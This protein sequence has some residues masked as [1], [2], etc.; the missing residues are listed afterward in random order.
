[1]KKLLLSLIML[2]F[3]CFTMQAQPV[4]HLDRTYGGPLNDGGS[5]VRQTPD[6]GYIMVGLTESYGAGGTDI[7]LI[8]ADKYG[9]ILWTK[10]YGGTG[11][12]RIMSAMNN[13]LQITADGGY[14][15]IGATTSFGAG[16]W[17]AW[18][19]KTDAY[20]DTLWTKTFG[21][22]SLDLGYVVYQTN[23]GGYIFTGQ[24]WGFGSYYNNVWLVKTDADGNLEWQK[25]YP[26]Y[27]YEAGQSLQQTADGGYLVTGLTY[28]APYAFLL[29]TDAD[30][31]FEWENNI[32]YGCGYSIEKT[33]D[34]GFIICGTTGGD[35]F[36]TKT[37]ATG[38]IL[39]TKVITGPGANF[40]YAIQQLDD[41]GYIVAGETNGFGGGWDYYVFRTDASGDTLWTQVYGGPGNEWAKSIQI[42][43]DGGYVM[44]GY[45]TSFGAGEGDFW[46]LKIKEIEYPGY[47]T[48]RVYKD[49]DDNCIYNETIDGLL[50]GNMLKAEPGPYY[51]FTD[52]QG[53]YKFEVEP[54][55]YT[56]S[57]AT[58]P[59]ELFGFQDCQLDT[60]YT[61]TVASGSVVT[62]NDFALGT[63]DPP[64]CEG[65]VSI[66][67]APFEQGDCLP[68]YTLSSPC[69]GFLHR[70]CFTITNT[71]T[72]VIG[73]G[74]NVQVALDPNMT[75]SSEVSNTCGTA[76]V[77]DFSDISNPVW[78]VTNASVLNN[79][80]KF[81]T[82]CF[83]VNVLG[84]PFPF[85]SPYSTTATFNACGEIYTDTELDYDVCSC[86]PNDKLV[87]PKGC[88]PYG[89][90]GRDEN[91]TYNI[92]FQNIGTGPAHNVVIRDT[93]D[94]DFDIFTLN[95]LNTSHTITGLQIN[96]GNEIVFSFEGIELP[97]SLS[98]PQGSKGFIVMELMPL[99]NL[100]NGTELTNRAA[101]YFDNNPPV[102][103]NTT[104]NTIR[105]Y[106]Y[107]IADFTA[108][109][110][111]ES[112]TDSYDFFYTGNTADNAT[113]YWDFG[114]DATPQF[115]TE[116]DPL[117]II[118][119]STGLKDVS[120]TLTR[121][122]CTSSVIQTIDVI[123]VWCG[124]NNNKILV[125]HIPPGNPENPQTICISLNALP[126]HLAHG[127]C[128]GPCF[129]SV[130]KK[131][132][133]ENNNESIVD[134]AIEESFIAYPNPFSDNTILSFTAS[135]ENNVLL[136]VYN[137]TGQKVATLFD[138][139][140][141]AGKQYKVE[142]N[143]DDLPQ[144]VYIGVL[145]DN[146][147][148]K[149]IRL[150]LIK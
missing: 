109:R 96:P 149:V 112:I 72:Q 19:I 14:I 36:L 116:K 20:G 24:T 41:G 122:G 129:N 18:L 53:N 12:D 79:N 45:T 2:A 148:T 136:Q 93:I 23:D 130:I 50:V 62:D 65:S 89:N 59:N 105:D 118:F 28:G 17:D 5:T 52:K 80:G 87:S 44:L 97:D 121:Y 127:D 144:G 92:R 6:G 103:T 123:N 137:Y 98:D 145:Q 71:G 91:I 40:A 57:P 10:T 76:L 77:G 101:I 21:S 139:T 15:I 48:G 60:S 85:G 31:N 9:D 95:I 32:I 38:N 63:K 94:F 78:N 64:V 126:A 108:N 119:S 49:D 81:C 117:G 114:A 142:F 61:V 83:N 35:S 133:A 111:C 143:T 104:L 124:N 90:T 125:C 22:P 68:P 56:V 141:V 39:W 11:T 27:N 42:T 107:P 25:N 46:L 140:V 43:D 1:M 113:F 82:V 70:Y 134:I 131:A 67:S 120:L 128:V 147:E 150:S 74:S 100:P 51:V 8:K 13:N 69:P 29:K 58:I 102:I 3:F 86:D 88:G 106:P 54:D 99:S 110:Q 7:Y 55:E 66:V 30:G 16:N 37:D 75:F 115:S 146:N 73:P 47:I 4:V 84:V 33:S 138:N 132:N 26:I 135:E 34:E